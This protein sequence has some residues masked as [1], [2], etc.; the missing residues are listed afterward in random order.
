MPDSLH[1][2]KIIL[3]I[4]QTRIRI[5][6]EPGIKVLNA[7]ARDL[8]RQAGVEMEKFIPDIEMPQIFAEV[9]NSLKAAPDL[10]FEARS[11]I[12]PDGHFFGCYV[13]C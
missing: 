10:A 4:R 7:E 12:E 8:F 1:S 6:E 11:S 3:A 13:R 2:A 5:L 9:F